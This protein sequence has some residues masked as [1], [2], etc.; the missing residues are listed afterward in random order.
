LLGLLVI[1]GTSSGLDM[2][3]A[4]MVYSPK[5]DSTANYY[6]RGNTG[7][8]ERYFDCMWVDKAYAAEPSLKARAPLALEIIKSENITLPKGLRS[9]RADY[10]NSNRTS[11]SI[12]AYFGPSFVGPAGTVEGSLPEGIDAQSVLWGQSLQKVTK[13]SV[14]S[15]SGKFAMPPIE[16]KN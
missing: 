14:T 7:T 6:S 8:N 3:N 13:D 2:T 15:F 11:L 9:T 12:T 5:C 4:R 1:Q 10:A 16:F